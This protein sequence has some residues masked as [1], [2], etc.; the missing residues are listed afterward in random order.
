MSYEKQNFTSGQ[1]LTAA[2]LNHMEDGIANAGGASSW[3]DL[4]DK[5][6]LFSGSWN[7]LTDKP[8]GEIPGE[9]IDHRHSEPSTAF[10]DKYGTIWG[11]ISDLTPTKEQLVGASAEYYEAGTYSSAIKLSDYFRTDTDECLVAM[12]YC[13]AYGNSVTVEGNTYS[14]T[15]GLYVKIDNL[16]RD[17]LYLAKIALNGTTSPIDPKYLPEALQ[18]GEEVVTNTV[19]VP[20]KKLTGSNPAEN[21]LSSSYSLRLANSDFTEPLIEGATYRVTYNG[22]VYDGL[23][24]S[25]DNGNVYIG[26]P[27]HFNTDIGSAEGLHFAVKNS[28][29]G[30]MS[31]YVAMGEYDPT[32]LVEKISS[33][34]TTLDEKYLPESVKGGGSESGAVEGLNAVFFKASL[35]GTESVPT[36]EFT[37]EE[38][39]AAYKDGKS[40]F[41]ILKQNDYDYILPLVDYQ[42]Y[43]RYTPEGITFRGFTS[44]AGVGNTANKLCMRTVSIT[45]EVEDGGDTWISATQYC[46]VFTM[47]EIEE[48]FGTTEA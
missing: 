40:V 21:G 35:N 34:I 5:P 3:N 32:I 33:T 4:T 6:D 13:V 11:K 48:H 18:F 37:C 36:V 39:I 38:A 44:T 8:F 28:I 17:R 45:G 19:V 22:V 9:V 47:E 29:S 46:P 24:A 7:D 23:I 43:S 31:F 12:D 26:N 1:V 20:E 30:Y 15:P 2:A 42:E 25:S 16:T 41:C 27:W 10:N 14:V